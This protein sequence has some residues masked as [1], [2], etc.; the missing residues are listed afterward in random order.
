MTTEKTNTMPDPMLKNLLLKSDSEES[1]AINNSLLKKSFRTL[2][3]NFLKTFEDYFKLQVNV[4]T[5]HP[6]SKL[7]RMLKNLKRKT[8]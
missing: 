8:S 4:K 6:I 5:A 2:T 7:F 3:E 1:D